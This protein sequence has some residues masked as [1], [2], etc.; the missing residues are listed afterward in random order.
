MTVGFSTADEVLG[1]GGTLISAA[2]Q[3]PV[4]SQGYAH[5]TD[6]MD[7]HCAQCKHSSLLNVSEQL[8]A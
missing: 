6:K 1:R 3:H 7:I 8:R 4:L 2:F 5:R